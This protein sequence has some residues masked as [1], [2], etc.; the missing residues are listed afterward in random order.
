MGGIYS[1]SAVVPRIVFAYHWRMTIDREYLRQIL[2]K[3]V[4]IDSTNPSLSA[5]GA[6]E[7]EVAAYVQQL[8]DELGLAVT[9]HEPEPGR[10]SVVGKLAGSGGG[11][12]LL[13]NAHTDTVGVVGMAEPFS[14]DV[15]DGKLYGRGSYDMKG[16]L[17]A[18]I[19]AVAA[20]RDADL[21][22]DVF[23]AAVADEEYASIGVQSIL[24]DYR[25]NGVIV[26]EPSELEIS[27]AHKGFMLLEV[28]TF[29]RA[30]HGSRPDLG[31]DANRHMGRVLVE[32]DR[33]DQSLAAKPP[34]PLLGRASLHA[35]TIHGGT[36][37]SSYASECVLGV[38]RRTLPGE[39][40]EE[41]MEEIEGILERLRSAD[42][43]FKATL[44]VVMV[45]DPFE[46]DPAAE[47]VQTLTTARAEVLGSDA[48]HI[49]QMFWTDAAFHASAG[50]ET[51][52]IG[53]SGYGLHSAEEWVDLESVAQLAEILARTAMV[54]CG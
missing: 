44:N 28:R 6:G 8:F 54:Y 2:S 10:V 11:R 13:L 20:L 41:V 27:V 3:L 4:Q 53:P 26:T 33:L 14:G 52:L 39:T 18:Q 31:I 37:W 30:Y 7:A 19:A 12:S 42:S 23:V 35:S 5:D 22:G 45:R 25:P 1:I 38:E 40:V 51:V 15:R 29:G 21:K 24:D 16:S 50:S 49:G 43:N 9:T 36:E 34:H 17:A 32:L 47:L 46:V 48:P